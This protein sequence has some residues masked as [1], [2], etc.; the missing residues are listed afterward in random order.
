LRRTAQSA[1]QIGGGDLTHRVEWRSGDDLGAIAAEINRMAVRLRDLRETEAGRRQ[2]DQQLSDAVVHSIFEPVIVTDAKGHVLKLNRSAQQLLGEASSD[3]NALANTPGGDRILQAIRNAVSMQRAATGEGEAALLPMRTGQAEHSYRLRTTPIRD[4]RGR[5]LGAV[6]LLED[7][8]EMAAV[9]RFK[10]RFLMVAS[11]KLRDPLQ[12]LRLSLYTLTRGFAGPLQPLQMDI[13]RNGEEE[14]ERLDDLM[15]DLLEVAELDTGDRELQ[16]RALRPLDV[17]QDASS[18]YRAEA[19]DKKIRL[20]VKA[21]EDLP[22]VAGDRRALRSIL[23]NL[24]QNS[25]RY[26]P[27]EGEIRLE[28]T[29]LR[30]RVQFAV[31]DTGRGIEPERLSGIFG[32]FSGTGAA[33]TGLGLALVRRLVEAQN[34]E[35]AVESRLGHGTTFRFTLPIAAVRTGRHPVEAG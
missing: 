18:R 6:T 31:T 12:R 29:E 11:Q 23:D 13:A 35:V 21:Y 33:G 17:L 26:T 9:D 1:R 20:C 2:M 30:D 22:H 14:A 10:S 25:L 32:R 15:A 16:L 3:R 34:G 24:I 28:A 4:D 5:L 19:Q 8:T 27:P 7:I